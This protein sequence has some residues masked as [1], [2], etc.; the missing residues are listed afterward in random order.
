MNFRNT[1]SILDSFLDSTASYKPPNFSEYS[2]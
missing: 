2:L 1:A